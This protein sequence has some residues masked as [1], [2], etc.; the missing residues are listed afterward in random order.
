MNN[1]LNTH[2]ARAIRKY[3][4]ENFI[5]EQIDIATSV[6]ELTQKE[7]YWVHYYNTLIEGYNEVDPV[8][9]SGGNTYQFKTKEEM[10]IIREKISLS[11][12]GGLNPQAKKIKCK[13]ISTQEELHFNSLSEAQNYFGETNHNFI[14]RR[15]RGT[16]KCLFREEWLFAYEENNY[17]DDYTIEKVHGMG[18]KIK[19]LDLLI[20]EERIFSNFSEAERFYEVS[21]KAFRGCAAAKRKE[22]TFIVKKRYKI[23]MLE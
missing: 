10:S 1:I 4:P 15:C 3:G 19:V 18:K 22:K 7:S 20:N 5:V 17:P 6:E 12:M 21:P 11:K 23:T 14:S 9:R 16:I 8:Y 13:N 2:L